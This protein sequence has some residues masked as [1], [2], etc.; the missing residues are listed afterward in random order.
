MRQMGGL[1]Q[2]GRPLG[3]RGDEVLVTGELPNLVNEPE[4]LDGMAEVH[5]V[6]RQLLV[7]GAGH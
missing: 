5:V 7:L 6:A 1:Q 3:G 4:R 2:A